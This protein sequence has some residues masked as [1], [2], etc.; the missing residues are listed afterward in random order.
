MNIS[1]IHSF[2]HRLLLEHSFEAKLPLDVQLLEEKEAAEWKREWFD[3][4]FATLSED[5]MKELK[6]FIGYSYK[7]YLL[8]AFLQISDMAEEIAIVYDKKALAKKYQ[9]YETD[10]CTL[11]GR[12]QQSIVSGVNGILEKNYADLQEVLSHDKIGACYVYCTKGAGEWR[13]EG[14]F[15]ISGGRPEAVHLPFPWSRACDLL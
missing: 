11:R 6:Q 2:C 5:K 10:F 15:P 3:Q 13:I 12:I 14:R 1:T 4:W 8:D 9:E 7:G